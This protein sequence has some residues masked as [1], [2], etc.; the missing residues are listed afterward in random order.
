MADR[1]GAFS[2][3]VEIHYRYYLWHANTLVALVFAWSCRGAAGGLFHNPW[4]DFGFLI[5]V[6]PLF[7]GSRDNLRKYYQ[8]SSRL[9]EGSQSD[10]SHVGSIAARNQTK[11]KGKRDTPS[12][13]QK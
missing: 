7:V 1:V 5:L 3:L 12:D 13:S 6:V 4:V 2:M 10:S 8:R 9:L 11:I